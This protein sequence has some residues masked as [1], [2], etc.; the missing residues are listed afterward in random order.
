MSYIWELPNRGGT[1]FEQAI[2][3]ANN[4]GGNGQQGNNGQQHYSWLTYHF[5]TQDANEIQTITQNLSSN[6][7]NNVK[8]NPANGNNPACIIVNVLDQATKQEIDNLVA[9]GKIA[10]NQ[11]NNGN[12]GQPQ[13]QSIT[14]T[15][16]EDNSNT[17]DIITKE[18]TRLGLKENTDFQFHNPQNQGDPATLVIN[19]P[20]DDSIIEKFKNNCGQLVEDT[21]PQDEKDKEEQEQRAKFIASIIDQYPDEIKTKVALAVYFLSQG[22]WFDGN[23]PSDQNQVNIAN[24]FR[25][26]IAKRD[27][28]KVKTAIQHIVTMITEGRIKVDPKNNGLY[29]VPNIEKQVTGNI[30]MPAMFES[31]PDDSMWNEIVVT[32]FGIPMINLSH[33]AVK[34]VIASEKP[35]E[36]CPGE[37]KLFKSKV[38]A[39]PGLQKVFGKGGFNRVIVDKAFNL[40]TLGVAGATTDAGKRADRIVKEL[41]EKGGMST[42]RNLLL[43]KYDD[44]VDADPENA[45]I[46]IKALAYNRANKKF[47]G[48]LDVPAQTLAQFYSAVDPVKSS[49]IYIEM[50]NNPEAGDYATMGNGASN[51]QANQNNQSAIVS[52]VTVDKGEP[53]FEYAGATA[54]SENKQPLYE[55][56]LATALAVGAAAAVPQIRNLVAGVRGGNRNNAVGN[57]TE[58]NGEQFAKLKKEYVEMLSKEGHPPSYILKPKS[59]KKEVVVISKA[60]TGHLHGGKVLMVSLKITDPS[61]DH[62]AVCF[63]SPET[64]KKYFSV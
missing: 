22:R 63:M 26:T 32:D 16:K 60:S 23:N 64:V 30:R 27:A 12:N 53:L 8:V 31:E 1:L 56:I 14:F 2:Y 28:E 61:G 50:Y 11:S 51:N 5:A 38:Y 47:M 6:F 21:R 37:L 17:R 3:E 7:G 42:H 45:D 43:V 46:T 40:L 13:Q 19:K 34:K 62:Q 59:A 20:N 10:Q 48:E 52:S 44:I 15:L 57:A 33:P 55:Y 18:L 49:K 58:N 29:S 41:K 9:S 54:Q 39:N 24:T 25:D 35:E 36:D 4:P